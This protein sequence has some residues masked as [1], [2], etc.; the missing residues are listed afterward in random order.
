[1]KLQGLCDSIHARALS[2][3]GILVERIAPIICHNFKVFVG[4]IF[5]V[6]SGD[7]WTL[8]LETR[9]DGINKVS[10]GW[11]PHFFKKVVKG[12]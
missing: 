5:K 3:P 12:G 11:D 4:Q 6:R 2:E 10:R 9:T 7:D 8:E 1:M